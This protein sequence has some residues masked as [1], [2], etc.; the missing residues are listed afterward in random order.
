MSFFYT[1]NAPNFLKK[2]YSLQRDIP[3]IYMNYQII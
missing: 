2:S 3:T 1:L